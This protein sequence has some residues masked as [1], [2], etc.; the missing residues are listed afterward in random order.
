MQDP[1]GTAAFCH[2]HNIV[3][4]VTFNPPKLYR[5]KTMPE[6][7]KNCLMYEELLLD[8]AM[9]LGCPRYDICL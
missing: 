2:H 6:L 1:D 9:T 3:T 8:S 4:S 7:C 5:M